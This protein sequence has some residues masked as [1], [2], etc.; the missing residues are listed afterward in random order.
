MHCHLNDG[1]SYMIIELKLPDIRRLLYYLFLKECNN[2]KTYYTFHGLQDA[3]F[4]ANE[5]KKYFKTAYIEEFK[6][7]NNPLEKYVWTI[8]ENIT[9]LIP[10]ENHFWYL[11]KALK[12]GF[13]SFDSED[14]KNFILKEEIK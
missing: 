3:Y 2:L 6:K 1:G 12:R 9:I 10:G 8:N 7:N 4:E 11:Y 5:Y 14:F 13:I